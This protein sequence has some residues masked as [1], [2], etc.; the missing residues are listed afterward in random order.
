MVENW[1]FYLWMTLVS[2]P[3]IVQGQDGWLS[4]GK[5]SD[6]AVT[7]DA[8]HAEILAEQWNCS[9]GEVYL[10]GHEFDFIALILYKSMPVF[11]GYGK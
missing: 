7:S 11:S 5:Q 2:W 1:L 3:D 6:L 10:I 9:F 4:H 8:Q